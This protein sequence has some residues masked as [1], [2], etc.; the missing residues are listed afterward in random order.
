MRT[1]WCLHLGLLCSL[2]GVAP[3]VVGV[4]TSAE[5]KGTER[6]R[7]STRALAGVRGQ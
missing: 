4:P 6:L 2:V 3:V 5:T 1:P 7:W